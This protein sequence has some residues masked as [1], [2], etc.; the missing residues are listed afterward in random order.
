[1]TFFNKFPEF[2]DL[3]SRKDRGFS[4]VTAET[5][6]NRHETSLPAWAVDGMTVLDLGSCL[7]ATGHWVLS[8]GAKHYTGV[9]VQPELAKISQTLLSKHWPEDKFKINQIDLRTFFKEEIAQG[10]KYDVVVM[11]G[12]IYAFLD[13]YGILSQLAELCD[14]LTVIDSIYPWNMLNPDTPTVDVLRWQNINSNEEKTAFVGA[15][16]RVSPYALR[17]Y[18]ET[19]GFEDKEGILYPKPI[20]DKTIHDTY[21]SPIIRPGSKSY[22]TPAR[23]MLRFYNT[24]NSKLKQVADYVVSNNSKAKTAMKEAPPVKVS[25]TWSFDDNVAKRFQTEAETHIPDYQR[26]IDLCMSYTRQVFGDNKNI[27]V[28]DVGSALGHTMDKYIVQGYTN[29]QGIENS[30]SMINSS[31]HKDQVVLSNTFVKEPCDVVLANW[32]LHF[33][34]DREQY[35]RDIFDSLNP[36]G[37]L[38]VSDKMD[39]TVETENLYYDFKRANGVSEDII[40]KKKLAL[41]GILVTKPLTWYVD[42]LKS[43]GFSDIQVVNSR[44]MFSTIYARKL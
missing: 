26:V 22:P 30:Q 40:Q 7:G 36:N 24:G 12:V 5:L 37:M 20:E 31:K 42:T 28:V 18:M 33:I 19:L 15:G 35:L 29:V 1:M 13:T 16:S 8:N 34:S 38:I 14:Y 11:V 44:Y 6:D 41:I 21:N 43:V 10:K 32:T 9:E 3:D 17:L 4:P 23:F 2:V 27:T 25:E 39:H